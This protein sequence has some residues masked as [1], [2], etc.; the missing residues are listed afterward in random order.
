MA[1]KRK[2]ILPDGHIPSRFMGNQ[3]ILF[4]SQSDITVVQCYYDNTLTFED[5]PIWSQW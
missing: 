4:K 2:E 3:Y 1:D 5:M